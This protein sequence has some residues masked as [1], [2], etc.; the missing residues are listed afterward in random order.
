MKKVG[1]QLVKKKNRRDLLA[2]KFHDK[3]PIISTISDVDSEFRDCV[4]IQQ[5]EVEHFEFGQ[6][7]PAD[8]TINTRLT[9]P[10]VMSNI[11]AI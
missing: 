11:R 2:G 1:N 10:S 9:T 7:D 3:P 6:D 8:G 5:A 4:V